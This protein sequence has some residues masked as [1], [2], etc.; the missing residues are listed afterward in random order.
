M[1]ARLRRGGRAG[2][3]PAPV[4]WFRAWWWVL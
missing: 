3:G 4:A 2:D 1:M